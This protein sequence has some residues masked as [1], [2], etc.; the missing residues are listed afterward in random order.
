[1]LFFR[2]RLSF[3]I[4][5]SI[6]YIIKCEP[7]RC[8]TNS[9]AKG[10]TPSPPGDDECPAGYIG[11]PPFYQKPPGVCPD[12]EDCP[13]PPGP[14]E[15]G[16]EGSGDEGSGDEG[17]RDEGGNNNGGD[18]GGNN[19]GGDEGGNNNGGDEGSAE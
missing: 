13:E 16:Y 1:M 5:I 11:K 2:P 7:L 18:E 4:L 3:S 19:N 8:P 6:T 15:N 12:G 17:S 14:G 10:C 9:D